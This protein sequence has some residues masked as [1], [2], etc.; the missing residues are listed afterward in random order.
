MEKEQTPGPINRWSEEERPREKLLINGAS[1]MT[2]SELLAILLRTGS[3]NTSAL[4]LSRFIMQQVDNDLSKLAKMSVVNLTEFIGVGEAKAI[5]IVAALELGRRRQAYVAERKKTIS[6]SKDVVE[7]ISPQLRDFQHEE[8]WILYLDNKNSII[9]REV[10]SK[11]GLDATVV[12][13]RIILRR[14]LEVRATGMICIHNH[15]SGNL[16]PSSRDQQVTEEIA[17]AGKLMKI[18]LLDHIIIAG[19]SHFSFKDEGLL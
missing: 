17:K 9:E 15:P 8:F 12:D 11:G 4:D 14:A 10:M 18:T 3:R 1:A 13:V 16:K 7:I 5:T 6:S 2:N 19:D